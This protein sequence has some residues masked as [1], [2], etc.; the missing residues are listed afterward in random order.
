MKQI[1]R[2]WDT[3]LAEEL[4]LSMVLCYI[5]AS[6]LLQMADEIKKLASSPENIILF[7]QDPPSKNWGEQEIMTLMAK[8]YELQT[9]FKNNTHLSKLETI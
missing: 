8:S 2:I 6:M 1:L 4:D 3:L 7:L 5:C 9:L